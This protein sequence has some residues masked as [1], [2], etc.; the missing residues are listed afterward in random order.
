MNKNYELEQRLATLPIG[1]HRAAVDVSVAAALVGALKAEE[2]E[3]AMPSVW[4]LDFVERG[5]ARAMAH[6]SQLLQSPTDIN[7]QRI[8]LKLQTLET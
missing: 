2:S 6:T 8:K 3:M 7:Q 1:L 4:P 5:M